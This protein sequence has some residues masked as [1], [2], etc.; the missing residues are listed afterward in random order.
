[1][2]SLLPL[3]FSYKEATDVSRHWCLKGTVS[4][5]GASGLNMLSRDG[6]MPIGPGGRVGTLL[7]ARP[8]LLERLC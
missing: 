5:E 1:M 7:A 4:P 6:R 3:S 8:Q 2:K